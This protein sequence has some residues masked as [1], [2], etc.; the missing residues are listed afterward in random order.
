MGLMITYAAY[1]RS[2]ISL[3]QVAVISIV[4]DTGISILAGLAVFPIVFAYHLD[5]AS[6]AGLVFITLP[7][8]FAQ[9]PFGT[10]AASAFFL[11]LFIAALASAI[12]TLEL[13]VSLLI[14]RFGFRRCLSAFSAGLVCFLAGVPTV[15]SFN[16]W[17]T[18]YPLGEI[19]AFEKHTFYDLID[20]LT[21][22]ILLP[23]DGLFI[24]VFAGWVASRGFLAR[25]LRL[26][27][28]SAAILQFLLRY[29]VPGGIAAAALVFLIRA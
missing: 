5:P 1:G 11:L 7:I 2:D 29:V 3:T 26:S 18:W 6:G 22:N 16:L 20:Y 8:A 23:I 13:V 4:A 24:A 21:S 10:I 27:P 25:E 9:L 19:A 28:A 12:A 15:F 14:Q 17:G